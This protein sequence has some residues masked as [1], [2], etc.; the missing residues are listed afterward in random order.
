VEL[1][2]APHGPSEASGEEHRRLLQWVRLQPERYVPA[3][4]SFLDLERGALTDDEQGRLRAQNAATILVAHGGDLGRSLAVEALREILTRQRAIGQ[5]RA[6]ISRGLR[7]A[8]AERIAEARRLD[9][10]LGGLSEL[11]N[12]I[13]S[14]LQAAGDPRAAA[15]LGE[16]LRD[17]PDGLQAIAVPYLMQTAG[18]DAEVRRQ[19]RL[20]LADPQSTFYRNPHLAAFLGEQPPPGGGDQER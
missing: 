16:H 4:A 20:L 19:L 1:T 3:L 15:S 10:D 7:T 5:S 11:R 13:L 6:E 9:R 2:L 12:A 18:Q 8:T 17:N 14:A